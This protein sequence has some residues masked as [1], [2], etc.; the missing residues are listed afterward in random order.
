IL[1]HVRYFFRE[2]LHLNIS[3]SITGLQLRLPNK[4]EVGESLTACV[5]TLRPSQWTVSLS[6]SIK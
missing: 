2:Q 4:D 3:S 1:S 5:L 6:A